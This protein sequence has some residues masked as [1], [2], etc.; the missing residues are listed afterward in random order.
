MTNSA[1]ADALLLV[2]D[3]PLLAA[4]TA[5]FL[6][7]GGFEVETALDLVTAEALLRERRWTGVVTDVDLTGRRTRDGLAVVATAAGLA[8]RPAILVWT[9]YAP[10]DLV[11]VA[12]RLG[13]DAVLEKGSLR[14]LEARLRGCTGR[15]DRPQTGGGDRPTP[16]APPSSKS[17]AQAGS[18]RSAGPI[19]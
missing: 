9:G 15:L 1:A 3:D 11:A 5:A 10:P 6:S 7:R 4:S 2:E 8:P 17:P 14:E 12:L 19:R 13:A 16:F 18:A